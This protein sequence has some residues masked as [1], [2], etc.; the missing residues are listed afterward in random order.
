[1]FLCVLYEMNDVV[2]A[3]LFQYLKVFLAVLVVDECLVLFACPCN[4]ITLHIKGLQAYIPFCNTTFNYKIV[5]YYIH[6]MYI[7]NL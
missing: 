7:A 5:K 2:V 4:L 1:M 6:K 3:M